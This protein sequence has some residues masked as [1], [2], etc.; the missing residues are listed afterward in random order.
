MINFIAQSSTNSITEIVLYKYADNNLIYKKNIQLSEIHDEIKEESK[1]LFLIPSSA[2]SSYPN[3]SNEDKN[4]DAVFISSIEDNIVEDISEIFVKT[5]KNNGFVIKKDLI[6]YLNATLS[7][8]KSRIYI[9]PDYSLFSNKEDSI[10]IHGDS[11]IFS[12]HDRTGTSIEK[13]YAKEYLEIVKKNNK[14]YKPSII[15]FESE[16]DDIFGKVTY[17]DI[18]SYHLSFLNSHQ[19]H[20][21]LFSFK[22]SLSSI[23]NKLDFTKLQLGFLSVS[24]IA[25]LVLP[26][27]IIDNINRNTQ[28]YKDATSGIFSSLSTKITRVINPR[29][30]IDALIGD[31]V[32]TNNKQEL[33][34]IDF[35]Y[36]LGGKFVKK[37]DIDFESS[38]ALIDI[39]KMPSMQMS[40]VLSMGESFGV[41]IIDQNI[42]ESGDGA[43]GTITINFKNE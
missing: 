29:S 43:T 39:E 32:S 33:P 5:S 30:Q 7:L 4:S 36:R 11:V 21:N 17:K 42:I 16:D 40:L 3:Q 27:L 28:I 2:I 23:L 26:N 10:V 8:V 15:S 6:N 34:N 31:T 37:I 22:Y 14:D 35:I 1:L 20:T 25:I 19:Q 38:T 13:S 24:L 18:G 12:H 41:K 9:Y